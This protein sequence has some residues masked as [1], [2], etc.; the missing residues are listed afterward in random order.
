M[1]FRSWAP[2]QLWY[3][4]VLE[5]WLRYEESEAASAAPP[6]GRETLAVLSA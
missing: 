5:S 2:N 4:Y 6:G 1:L 3:V